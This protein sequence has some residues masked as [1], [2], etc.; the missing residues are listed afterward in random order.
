MKKNH[1]KVWEDKDVLVWCNRERQVRK[2]GMALKWWKII[3]AAINHKLHVNSFELQHVKVI[4][5]LA[6][7]KIISPP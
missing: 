3:S 6:K 2:T 7:L 4:S 1:G 5:V